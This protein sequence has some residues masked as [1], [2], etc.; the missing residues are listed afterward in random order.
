M[1]DEGGADPEAI[2]EAKRCA[3]R[4]SD[5]DECSFLRPSPEALLEM[6]R[7]AQFRTDMPPGILGDQPFRVDPELRS[8]AQVTEQEESV[9]ADVGAQ[10]RSELKAEIEPLFAQLELDGEPRTMSVEALVDAIQ[11]RRTVGP[12]DQDRRAE[13]NAGR[14]AISRA[15]AGLDPGVS[16]STPAARLEFILAELGD[17]F[18]RALASELGAERADE[19]RS[20][21]D[22]WGDRGVF[23]GRC[24]DDEL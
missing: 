4:I 6:S 23:A 13:R 20:A 15:R 22:G 2:L 16:P 19:L 11:E 5:D 7:C 9:I 18:E 1:T 17:R 8:L 10:V 14:R 3:G 24:E 12:I 21:A